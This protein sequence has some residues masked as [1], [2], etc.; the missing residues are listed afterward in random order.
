MCIRDSGL[1]SGTASG[2]ALFSS[3]QWQL[4]GR[5]DFAGG[6]WNVASGSGGFRATISTNVAGLASDDAISWQ[7]DGLV[8]G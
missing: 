6:S 4:R 3:G 7:L 2:E 5:S 8:A 1:L